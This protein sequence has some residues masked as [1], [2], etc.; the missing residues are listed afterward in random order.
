[1]RWE[2]KP[3]THNTA[4][5]VARIKKDGQHAVLL[6]TII[7]RALELF[8][9][10][11]TTVVIATPSPATASEIPSNNIL[12]NHSDTLPP[13]A[14]IRGFFIQYTLKEWTLEGTAVW[15]FLLL[16]PA[17]TI[18]CQSEY[19]GEGIKESPTFS[20]KAGYIYEIET[21]LLSINDKCG[22]LYPYAVIG[23]E[24]DSIKKQ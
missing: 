23:H 17:N 10:S 22:L 3:I 6:P 8:P 13:I 20:E 2:R 15:L 4:I 16:L 9:H 18:T 24:N 14:G 12:R 7:S 1:V 19:E 5:N 21:S 11:I